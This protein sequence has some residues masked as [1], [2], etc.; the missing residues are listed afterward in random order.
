MTNEWLYKYNISQAKDVCV[1][2]VQ[3]FNGDGLVVYVP[4]GVLYSFAH[5]NVHTK[6]WEENFIYIAWLCSTATA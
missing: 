5:Q 3:Y 2:A 4:G 1:C 6:I